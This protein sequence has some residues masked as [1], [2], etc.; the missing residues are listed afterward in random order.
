MFQSYFKFSQII[1]NLPNQNYL[2]KN[3]L[4]ITLIIVVKKYEHIHYKKCIRTDVQYII[5]IEHT[6][7]VV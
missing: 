2:T 3:I 7:R 1:C 4:I 6:I 5:P